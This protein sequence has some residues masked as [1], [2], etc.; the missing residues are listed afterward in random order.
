MPEPVTVAAPAHPA[1]G[2]DDAVVTEPSAEAPRAAGWD[3]LRARM[4][5]CVACG[6]LAARRIQVVPGECP[7]G[8]ELLLL[9]EAPGAT[10]D[11]EGL[12]FVGRS[13]AVLD[14]ILDEAGLAR[15]SVAVVNV[16]KCRPPD[17]RAPTR[18]EAANCRP[19]LDRQLALAD[20]LLVVTLGLTAAVW[21]LGRGITLTGV[22]GRLHTLGPSPQGPRPLIATYHPSAALRFGPRGRPR[23]AMVDDFVFARDL[24]PELRARRAAGPG[25]DGAPAEGTQ[26]EGTQ[27]EGQLW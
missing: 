13:G 18:Q 20:P 12:P 17:N 4:R 2:L 16:L 24:L 25:P 7:P 19:W 8:A 11:A 26:T 21:A 23:A 14:A 9:G 27:R 15:A 3:D 10:E 1:L 22:R 6:E 5:G